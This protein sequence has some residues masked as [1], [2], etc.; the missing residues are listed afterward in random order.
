LQIDLVVWQSA[1][2]NLQ[3]AICNL[4]S[5]RAALY[6]E[7]EGQRLLAPDNGCWTDLL[8]G[9]KRPGRVV[10]LAEPRYWLPRV[11][12][13]FHGRDV[14]APAAA[15]L[16]LGVDPAL[17]GPPAG[18]WV[19]LPTSAPVITEDHLAGEVTLVDPFGNL[20][21]NIPGEA[22]LRWAGRPVTVRVGGAE[23]TRRVRTYGEAAAGELV[24]LVSSLGTLEVAVC[25]GSAAARLG[26]AV[27]APVRVEPR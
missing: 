21:T 5:M 2:C 15:H 1:I 19:T 16:S 18:T 14:F 24:A 22:F 27:G 10:R 8:A 11:S 26:A 17:L 4:Q 6:V 20:I 13:T 3:S 25:Q 12:S 7:V 23:V 9:G